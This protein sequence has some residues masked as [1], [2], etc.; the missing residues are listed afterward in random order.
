M[1]RRRKRIARS[2]LVPLLGRS[3]A[4]YPAAR[5]TA[6]VMPSGKDS[7]RFY[8]YKMSVANG[9]APCVKD[10]LLSLAICKPAIR[11]T[12]KQGDYVL[13]FAG[14]R[15]RVYE[16]EKTF[17]TNPVVFIA[18]ITDKVC[19]WRYYSDPKFAHRPDCIYKWKTGAFVAKGNGYH[20][21]GSIADVGEA[22]DWENAHTL[23]SDHF[24]YFG[25]GCPVAYQNRYS[26]I[27]DVIEDLTQGHRVVRLLPSQQHEVRLLSKKL[28]RDRTKWQQDTRVSLEGDEQS[29]WDCSETHAE[30]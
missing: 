8:L 19:G 4:S 22:P 29:C 27:R 7:P 24:A 30:G 20:P 12:A 18:K 3:P 26:A 28:L 25:E 21:D 15:M 23:L 1:K 14:N 10:G 6:S 13:G 5:Y 11:R 16:G 17:P 9:G 2:I